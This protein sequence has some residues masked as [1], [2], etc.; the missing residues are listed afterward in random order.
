ME[1]EKITFALTA[2]M[3]VRTDQ[4]RQTRA[5]IAPSLIL[6]LRI[7]G[8]KQF[9][10]IFSLNG[11]SASPPS[12]GDNLRPILLFSRRNSVVAAVL[13][14]YVHLVPT[15]GTPGGH[16]EVLRLPCS[17]EKQALAKSVEREWRC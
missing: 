5:F 11:T 14:N 8:C 7:K 2:V 9:A 10:R 13:Q 4:L 16:R 1:T 3:L 15:G 17:E 6:G 12:S